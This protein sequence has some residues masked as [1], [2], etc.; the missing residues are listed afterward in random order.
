MWILKETQINA[1]FRDDRI[2]H[3]HH[4]RT[5]KENQLPSKIKLNSPL[6][7]W[8]SWKLPKCKTDNQHPGHRVRPPAKN[9]L[10]RNSFTS[11]TLKKVLLLEVSAVSSICTD[12]VI[13][14][15]I[16]TQW[17][18]CHV[19]SD[20]IWSDNLM[21]CWWRYTIIMT[22]LMTSSHGVG[23]IHLPRA[24]EIYR[25]CKVL[26]RVRML[27]FMERRGV[28]PKL[29]LLQTSPKLHML[30]TAR[31]THQPPDCQQSKLANLANSENLPVRT[32]NVP[33][34]Q[35]SMQ[36]QTVFTRIN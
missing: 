15:V 26:C 1:N 8:S 30:R 17:H 18:H 2:Q 3:I 29:H 5:T 19:I 34:N 36:P 23:V 13:N 10:S 27:P 16:L 20:T 33:Q 24:R 4:R 6:R 31:A 14:N 9:R 21:T 22:S 32:H 35:E 28:L 12:D 7:R 11:S 25:P